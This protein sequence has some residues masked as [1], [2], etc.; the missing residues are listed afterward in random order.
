MKPAWKMRGSILVGLLWCLALLSLVVISVLHTTRMDLMVVK[1]YGDKIQAHYIA[2]A[3]IEKA[4]AL[5]YRDA[6]QRSRSSVNHNGALYD[7]AEQLRDIHFGR[8]QFRVFRRGRP[9]EGGAII[10]GVSDEESRLNV[11]E[12]SNEELSKLSGMT[13]DISAAIV[14]WRSAENSDPTPGG[15]RAD[16]Y[17]SLR[18][19]YLPRNGPFQT[20][21]ELLM[22]R[23]VTRE[24][25][26]G[27][28][29]HQNGLTEALD[30]GGSE[31]VVD[32]V[33]ETG[34]AGLLTVDSS[35]NNLNA[36]GYDR[37][38]IQTADQTALTQV[39]GITA[40]IAKAIIA[41]RGRNRFESIA[42]LLDVVAAQND[43]PAGGT[44][45]ATQGQGPGP[46]PGNPQA[47]NPS[48]PKVISDSQLMDIA[49]DVTAQ[50]GADLA[51]VVNINTASL[52][53]L[54]CLP[55]ISRQL[56]QAIISFRQSSGFFSN[57]AGLLKVPGM[58]TDLFKQVCPLVTARSETFRIL[59][60][61]KVTSTGARQR[62]QEI[63]H[64][65]LRSVTTVSY[66]ED[67]L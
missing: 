61:G 24:L 30:E 51:G 46:G 10:Y 64:I 28:D 15:A 39:N 40:D 62:I 18:P 16:Y 20:I 5:L 48:G 54:V 67:D 6:R 55:G 45:N 31:A 57:V 50:A 7:A 23:G 3:G 63:V 29:I 33:L 14:D 60:E 13:P 32:D 52:E 19:P 42:G 56:A 58:T 59:S 4:K 38:N 47:G 44:G 27:R 34:W 41:W 8:G 17:L 25:L 1:N 53:V 66:R 22:V 37:V 12:A 11:N 21:R 26:L 65:G 43:N 35:V 2:V 49:D 36:A 9:D